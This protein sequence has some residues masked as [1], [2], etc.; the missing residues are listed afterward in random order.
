LHQIPNT[1]LPT[2][3]LEANHCFLNCSQL[4]NLGTHF[5]FNNVVKDISYFF[6]NSGI[7]NLEKH[8]IHLPTSIIGN[9]A[10]GLF[11]DCKRLTA[12]PMNLFKN[13]SALQF[14]S[15]NEFC[16]NCTNL[17]RISENKYDFQISD[18]IESAISIFENCYALTNINF[19]LRCKS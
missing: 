3:L 10:D 18:K 11:K 6:E 13:A 17:S 19:N 7:S 5:N 12:L 9:G 8:N 16:M 14:T 1:I 4:T 2:N 15:L